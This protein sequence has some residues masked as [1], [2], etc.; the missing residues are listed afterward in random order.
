MSAEGMRWQLA[1]LNPVKWRVDTLPDR[2]LGA[3]SKPQW[4]REH[5]CTIFISHQRR[6]EGHGLFLWAN[7]GKGVE[8]QACL[9]GW[10][11]D[12]VLPQWSV[13]GWGDVFNKGRTSVTD[14]ECSG[15]PSTATTDDKQEQV[16][17]MILKD[18]AR[19]CGMLWNEWRLAIHTIQRGRLSEG[20]VIVLNSVQ[21]HTA[22]FTKE[23][24][25]ELKIEVFDL[26]ACSS[27][28]APSDF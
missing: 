26:P 20:V 13:C 19:Y 7:G 10:L 25:W 9:C 24:L 8:V 1:A 16:R 3:V 14:S 4:S 21:L 5:G 18:T 28:L 22:V 12:S 6:T 2:N 15:C 23:T 27:V 11:W 17:S